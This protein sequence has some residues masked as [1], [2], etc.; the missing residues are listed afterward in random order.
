MAQLE[1]ARNLLPIA[2]VQNAYNVAHRSHDRVVDY[3]GS[4]GL[5]FIP[6]FP[7]GVGDLVRTDGPLSAAAKE[8]G[9]TP[10]QV[11]L[12][13][14]LHRSPAMLPIPGTA[15]VAHLEENVGAATVSLSADLMSA[16]D[17]LR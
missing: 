12:A 1:Q 9:A 14:L 10:G 16:L 5:A 2:S 17:E 7:M 13:W 8:C 6:Y 3:C 4:E 11:A 15:S